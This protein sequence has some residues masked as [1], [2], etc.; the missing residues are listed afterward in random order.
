MHKAI[1]LHVLLG[2]LAIWSMAYG[3]YRADPTTETCGQV[4]STPAAAIEAVAQSIAPETRSGLSPSDFAKACGL[5]SAAPNKS[6]GDDWMVSMTLPTGRCGQFK[7]VVF[8]VKVCGGA[9]SILGSMPS[10]PDLALP[11]P[12]EC[13]D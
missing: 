2:A 5:C 3:Y 13:Q 10:E 4:I 8:G 6:I 9:S 12:S 7:E 1:A 11:T